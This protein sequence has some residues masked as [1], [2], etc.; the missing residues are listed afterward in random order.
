MSIEEAVSAH[1]TH[2]ALGDAILAAAR[3]NA[4]NPDRLTVRDLSAVDEFHLGG[5]GATEHF[6]P[7]LGIAPDS[8]WLDV[9]SGIGGAARHVADRHGCRVTGIDLVTEFCAVARLL[10]E[11]V[12]LSDRVRFHEGSALAMPF[13]DGTFDG[14]YTMHVA[15]NIADKP[16][17]YR[18]VHRVLKPG[19]IFGLYDI[20]AGP[21]VA[22]LTFPVPWSSTAETSFLAPIGEML[23]M[24]EQAGFEILVRT[25]RTPFAQ[26]FIV[27]QRERAA[28]GLPP[29]GSVI[30]MGESFREK[31]DNLVA[32]IETGRC[33]PWEIVCRRR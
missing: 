28:A 6:V 10:T 26:Q 29:L 1:Y 5:V 18:D 19:A 8:H 31:V 32:N 12:G 20:L 9:G 14:A 23:A 24:L 4:A 7:Q 21:V 25:D 11:T 30:V 16:A 15:M 27:R 33:T 22:P 17:L 13:A 3:E 2:G